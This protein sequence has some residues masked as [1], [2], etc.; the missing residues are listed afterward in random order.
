MWLRLACHRINVKCATVS[1]AQRTRV[2]GPILRVFSC[3]VAGARIGGRLSASRS[4][5]HRRWTYTTR[6][7]ITGTSARYQRRTLRGSAAICCCPTDQS[8][9]PSVKEA[10]PSSPPSRRPTTPRK[11]KIGTIL[12]GA[13][14]C[15]STAHHARLTPHAI[16]PKN[17][18]SQG[19]RAMMALVSDSSADRPDRA[20]S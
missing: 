15:K 14:P 1:C 13:G 2:P 17:S 18:A 6:W 8:G 16:G 9:T 20:G 7:D 5:V 19:R 11:T 10:S 4:H 12:R 3:S